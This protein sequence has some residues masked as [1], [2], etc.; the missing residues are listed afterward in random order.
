MRRY[1]YLIPSGG[2]EDAT[3]CAHL[4]GLCSLVSSEDSSIL[5]QLVWARYACVVTDIPHSGF[6]AAH[7]Y[8]LFRMESIEQIPFKP[9][10]TV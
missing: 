3:L 2:G 8:P 4:C 5:A 10:V 1:E 7:I 9:I 6:N